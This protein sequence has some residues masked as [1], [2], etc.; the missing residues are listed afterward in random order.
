MKLEKLQD[1]FIES[2]LKKGVNIQEKQPLLV[3]APIEGVAFVRKLVK[4]AY[5]LGAS[6]V[7]VS[8]SD[9]ALT[10]LNLKHADK[11]VLENFPDWRV[12][13]EE[14]YVKNG[15]GL[16]SIHSTNPDLLTDIDSDRIALANKAA[17]EAMRNVSKEVMNDAVAWTVI[18]IP[19]ADWSHKVF[20]ELSK[21]A[22]VEAMWETILK[23][24]RVDG[25]DPLKA[26]D[27][28]NKTLYKAR[29]ALTEK[30]YDKLIFK[31]PGTNLELGLP[32]GHIWHGGAALA[33]SGVEFNPNMPTE[34]VFSMPHKYKVNGKVSSTK[35]LNYGGSLIDDFTLTFKDGQV[36]DYE[37]KQ[38][39]A[40]LGNLLKS[41]EGADRLGEVALVP[42]KS[43]I[44]E[45]GLIFYNTLFDENASCH[46]ALGKAYPTNIEN[47][48]EMDQATLDAHGVNDSLIH[49]D[50]MIGSAEMDIDGVKADGSTEAVFR[51]G[52]WAIEF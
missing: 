51:K 17:S 44:S 39:E 25:H 33:K 3:R 7:H 6:D 35:P 21:E 50:F 37:A 41:G 12:Q 5:E 52:A 15:A 9:D 27:E 32:K 14:S 19:T 22:A 2:I 16:I 23:M 40:V 1:Q 48:E 34:E 43:P 11:S 13:M 4:R 18:S 47:G 30:Q 46:L 49:V 29:V 20:P 42:H 38:G 10:Y 31:A 36:V 24:S 8:W 45:S 28:H 26:W